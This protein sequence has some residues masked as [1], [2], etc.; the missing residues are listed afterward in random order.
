M[1][2]LEAAENLLR[3]EDNGNGSERYTRGEDNEE[4]EMPRTSGIRDAV[5]ERPALLAEIEALKPRYRAYL[6]N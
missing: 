6:P 1:K 4:E 3:C 5:V 2:W